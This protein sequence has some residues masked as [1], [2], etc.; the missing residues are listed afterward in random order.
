ME[1]ADTPTPAKKAVKTG[2]LCIQFK[3]GKITKIFDVFDNKDVQ[4]IIKHPT[5]KT[6]GI[7]QHPEA[8]TIIFKEGDNE[9]KLFIKAE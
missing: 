9:M 5:P 1:R 8:G 6:E 3:N 4:I 2:E 7:V